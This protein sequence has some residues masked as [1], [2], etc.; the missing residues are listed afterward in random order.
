[1]VA[2]CA[3]WRADQVLYGS[4][5]LGIYNDDAVLCVFMQDSCSWRRSEIDSWY[6]GPIELCAA[7][8]ALAIEIHK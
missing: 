2:M 4:C 8:S 7:V 6:S 3:A 5:T 1:M